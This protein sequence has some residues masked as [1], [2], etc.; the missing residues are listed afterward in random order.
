MLPVR[1]VQEIPDSHTDKKLNDDVLKALKVPSFVPEKQLIV[2]NI[3]HSLH[4]I[5][6]LYFEQPVEITVDSNDTVQHIKQKVFEKIQN[7]DKK[8][9]YNESKYNW[10]LFHRNYEL[11]K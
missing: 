11:S 7:S 6:Q 3:C 5:K 8:N 9:N 10:K 4:K 2:N 1:Y